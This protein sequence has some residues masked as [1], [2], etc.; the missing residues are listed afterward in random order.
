MS[1]RCVCEIGWNNPLLVCP[2][3]ETHDCLQGFHAEHVWWNLGG[4]WHAL[5]HKG[6]WI[7]HVSGVTAPGPFWPFGCVLHLTSW[8]PP[9]SPPVQRVGYTTCKN[10]SYIQYLLT[11]SLVH[12]L[13]S[14]PTL[15][16]NTLFSGASRCGQGLRIHVDLC[17]HSPQLQAVGWVKP[18]QTPWLVPKRPTHNQ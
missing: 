16:T 2:C 1:G 14:E 8:G 10:Y 7:H 18:H 5:H 12:L 9:V 13:I 11:K 17:P 6:V 15:G 4:S 3:R